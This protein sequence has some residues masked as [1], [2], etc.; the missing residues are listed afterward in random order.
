MD[1]T[2]AITHISLCAGY[3]GID[4]GLRGAITNLRTVAFSEIEAFAV[5][6]FG[7]FQY[8]QS[9]LVGMCITSTKTKPITEWK[10]YA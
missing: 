8:A 4:L 6:T 9:L 3:G 10:T 2:Q 7:N 1:T 5:A